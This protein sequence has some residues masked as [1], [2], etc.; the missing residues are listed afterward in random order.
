MTEL[1]GFVLVDT[2]MYYEADKNINGDKAVEVPLRPSVDHVWHESSWVLQPAEPDLVA[3]AASARRHRNAL[4]LESDWTQVLD[5]PLSKSLQESW[6][7]YRLELRSVTEQPGF[8]TQ[9]SWPEK[10]IT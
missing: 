9:V 2:G 10:P 8:P 3:L 6:A 5:S 7:I 1:K 4:L